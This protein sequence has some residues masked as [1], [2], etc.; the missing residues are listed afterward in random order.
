MAELCRIYWYPLYAFVR[1]RGHGVQDAEDLTQEFFVRLLAKDQLAAVAP[2]KGKFR[3]FLLVSLKHFLANAWDRSKA[4]KR[5]G[6]KS[7]IVWNVLAAEQRYALEPVDHMTPE[8]LFERQ[9]A[10]AVLDRVLVRLQ[11]E[12]VVQH[13]DALRFEALKPFLT[14]GRKE[15]GYAEAAA[16]LGMTEGAFKVAVHRM[17]RQ[18][19]QLL[20]EEIAQTV[21]SPDEPGEIDDEIRYLWT[22]L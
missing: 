12:Y 5:G 20:Q 19:R 10:L 8:R 17:R 7:T 22:C 4:Q 14:T 11:A 21:A 18:Y 2:E 1:R 9:W 13:G 16:R 15:I 6:G 3:A